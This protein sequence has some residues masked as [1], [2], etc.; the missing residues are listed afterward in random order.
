VEEMNNNQQQG[1]TNVRKLIYFTNYS[2]D[3]DRGYCYYTLTINDKNEIVKMVEHTPTV[4]GVKKRIQALP[5][6]ILKKDTNAWDNVYV[7]FNESE[8]DKGGIIR[9]MSDDLYSMNIRPKYVPTC[10]ECGIFPTFEH[11]CFTE[12]GR[13]LSQGYNRI[14]TACLGVDEEPS[15]FVVKHSGI[16]QRID[17]IIDVIKSMIM[18]PEPLEEWDAEVKDENDNNEEEEQ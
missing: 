12:S 18:D 10:E 13:K 3:P 9:F 8:W 16:D 15:A 7:P 6:H 14:C 4:F 11:V 2:A 17:N 1:G 5:I